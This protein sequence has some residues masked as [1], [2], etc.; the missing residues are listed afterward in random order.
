MTW[1]EEN[2]GAVYF[3]GERRFSDFVY[4]Y[5]LD[6]P[7]IFNFVA[8]NVSKLYTLGFFSFLFLSI[9]AVDGPGICLERWGLRS[10]GRTGAETIPFEFFPFFFLLFFF[11]LCSTPSVQSLFLSSV[12]RD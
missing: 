9:F 4:L 6:S 1:G 7:F 12:G 10:T 11:Y 2:M 3:V 8:S 5:H